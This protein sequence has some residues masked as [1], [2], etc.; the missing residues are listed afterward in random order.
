M[1]DELRKLHEE[2][3]FRIQQ[4]KSLDQLIGL[5]DAELRRIEEAKRKFYMPPPPPFDL[6]KELMADSDWGKLLRM[7]I[8]D[9]PCEYCGSEF[10]RI[11]KKFDL[12]QICRHCK[13]KN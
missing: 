4:R 10:V 9:V 5:T 11:G 3:K 6:P 13:S 1:K 2:Y 12:C 8:S 7:K